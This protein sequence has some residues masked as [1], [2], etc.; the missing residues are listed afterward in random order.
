MYL[1]IWPHRQVLMPTRL[2]PK[3]S[4]RCYGPFQVLQ[5]VGQAAFRL[6]L[7][8]TAYI[9]PVCNVSQLK[10]AMGTRQ[11]EKELPEDL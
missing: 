9:H 2:H 3:L 6:H 7:P 5:Q 1:N 4:S 10:V 11:V 8:D